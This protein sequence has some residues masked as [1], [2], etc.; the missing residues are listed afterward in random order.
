MD[1]PHGLCEGQGVPLPKG[2]R[3]DIFP[4]LKARHAV[5][6]GLHEGGF[7]RQH[8]SG[9]AGKGLADPVGTHPL[10][11]LV[12]RG[13]DAIEGN[14]VDARPLP[15][16]AAASTEGCMRMK[17]ALGTRNERFAVVIGECGLKCHGCPR[18]YAGR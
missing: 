9:G 6:F 7:E 15:D 12:D 3:P 11:H 1:F 10:V 8:A 14:N 4:G 16:K 17:F 13:P 5:L 18:R 2:E